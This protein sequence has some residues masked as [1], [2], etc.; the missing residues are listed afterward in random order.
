MQS[1]YS[2]ITDKLFNDM[3]AYRLKDTIKRKL[4]HL[5][6]FPE[7]GTRINSYM[8]DISK[9]F[10]ECR[11]ITIGNYLII[12]NYFKEEQFTF[13]THIF[14]QMQDYGRLFQK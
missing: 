6:D 14:H 2:Y 3:A 4:S 11:K 9:E 1:I 5:E 7:T 12:Y 13:V 10:L 8:D